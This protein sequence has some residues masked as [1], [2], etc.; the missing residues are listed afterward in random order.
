MFPRKKMGDLVEGLHRCTYDV[1]YE[2]VEPKVVM[3]TF[4]LG[5]FLKKK[6]YKKVMH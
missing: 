3:K 5:P 6:K 4:D 2:S 1:N